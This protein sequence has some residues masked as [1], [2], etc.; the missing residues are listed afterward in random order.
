MDSF[1]G[2]HVL[3]TPTRSPG[4]WS[5]CASTCPYRRENRRIIRVRPVTLWRSR[6]NARRMTAI[7]DALYRQERHSC[8]RYKPRGEESVLPYWT[9]QSKVVN[10]GLLYRS[11]LLHFPI[12]R[13]QKSQRSP[14]SVSE[15]ISQELLARMFSSRRV[16]WLMGNLFPGSRWMAG[17]L[18]TVY[19][20]EHK[21]KKKSFDSRL[22]RI[23][24]G[25]FSRRLDS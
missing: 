23:V 1:N 14:R 13:W 17:F 21:M 19:W 18:Q 16:R 11:C 22:W 4:D 6:T 3:V 8:S 15:Y 12:D 7:T 24:G 5:S 25:K 9:S 2:S 20:S 10:A